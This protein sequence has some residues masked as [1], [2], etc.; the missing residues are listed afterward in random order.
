MT[1]LLQN[2]RIRWK[3]VAI[4]ALPALTLLSVAVNQIW[5]DASDRARIDREQRVLEIGIQLSRVAHELEQ[6]RTVSILYAGSGRR[7]GLDTMTQQRAR[8]DASIARL[9]G[10]EGGLEDT[11]REP[12]TR[13]ALLAAQAKLAEL[14]VRRGSLS[15]GE[16]A[17]GAVGTYYTDRVNE[18]LQAGAA[19]ASESGNPDVLRSSSALVALSQMKAA[20]S[21]DRDLVLTAIYTGAFGRDVN[22][23]LDA[24]EST[25]EV[26]RRRF[27]AAASEPEWTA[28]A[29]L[30]DRPDIAQADRLREIVT[31]AGRK[32]EVAA[33]ASDYVIATAARL[34][35]MR[36][37][38]E[39]VASGLI[40][41]NRQVAAGYARQLSLTVLIILAVL[42]LAIASAIGMGRSM[43]RPLARLRDIASDVAG[44]K[45]P[46]VVERLNAAEGNRFEPEAEL[47]L[48]GSSSTDEIGE[49]ARAFDAAHV[50]AMRVTSEQAALRRSIGA[51][52]LN[53]ARRSQTMIDRQIELIDELERAEHDPDA[54]E[55]LFR[56]DHLATRLRRNAE[57]LI[58]L[59]GARPT[60]RWRQPVALYD[61]VRAAAA[62][63]E[64]Y[65]RI[66]LLPMDD[67]GVSGQAVADVIHLLAELVENAT[68]FS[69]PGTKVHVAGQ[70]GPAGPDG[71]GYLVEIE[72]RG[73]GMSDDELVEA[74]QRLA[75][76]PVIDMSVPRKLGLFVIGRLSRRYGIT[77]EL[78]HSW[79]GGV[80][81]L[82]LL[83][84]GLLTSSARTAADAERGLVPAGEAPGGPQAI[85]GGWDVRRT[86]VPLRRH[87]GTS[88]AGLASAGPLTRRPRQSMPASPGP[89]AERQG[90]APD[91][92]HRMPTGPQP[93]PSGPSRP[94]TPRPAGSTAAGLPVR[95]P[96]SSLPRN[97]GTPEAPAE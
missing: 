30:S 97:G 43:V 54:L 16:A 83:P 60:R 52:Y 91:D 44:N 72:D 73:V 90:P 19:V 46:G 82:V 38:E 48:I 87:A 11:I 47:E 66:E 85:G 77:V 80:T 3:L 56:L 74:N 76:P 92:A 71:P 5:T 25:Q 42:G 64:D 8:V 9:R 70:P 12:S 39:Q 49:V 15:Q 13:T 2:L 41:A 78:R 67:V 62:E 94:G 32:G 34:D 17:P 14:P 68:S 28:F 4:F 53:L 81:A 93:A 20:Q 10:L 65:R 51:M 21:Q 84:A 7:E 88:V 58:V 55:E 6:E 69:P 63:V 31:A 75:S 23:G 45:L 33:Q 79:Y 27:L 24:A 50:A 89:R 59:S 1:S 36:V 37:T 61:V 86:Y 22:E 40:S 18:L 26:W 35:A 95:R 29:A 96:G 57:D